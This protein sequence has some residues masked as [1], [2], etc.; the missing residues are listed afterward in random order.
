MFSALAGEG[1]IAVSNRRVSRGDRL[2]Q[3]PISFRFN[4][5]IC[6]AVSRH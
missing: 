2:R 5:S 4:P 1:S 6:I 3:T